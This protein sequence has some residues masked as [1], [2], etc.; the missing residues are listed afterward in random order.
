MTALLCNVA[1]G[2]SDEPDPEQAPEERTDASADKEGSLVSEGLAATEAVELGLSGLAEDD[3]RPDI[4]PREGP[5]GKKKRGNFVA[6]PSVTSN[7]TFGTGL[8]LTAGYIVRL[9]PKDE[10]S[11][12]SVFGLGGFY[13]D[14]DS[15]VI[16]L[17]GK[18]YL[19][20]DRYRVSAGLAPFDLR[21]DFRSVNRATPF[22]PSFSFTPVSGSTP[23][24]RRSTSPSNPG[25]TW[26]LRLRALPSRICLSTSSMR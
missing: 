2:A 7:P 6:L 26:R 17:G 22:L 10:V 16:G 5:E 1:P 13:T 4:T 23:A 25:W 24:S 3:A 19:D 21:Y 15:W 12:P 20:E 11:P 18:L 14:S 9:N 8:R